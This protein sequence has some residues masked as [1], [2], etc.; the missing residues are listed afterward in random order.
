MVNKVLNFGVKQDNPASSL[1][2]AGYYSRLSNIK[3]KTA[4]RTE[5]NLVRIRYKIADYHRDHLLSIKA[6]YQQ[7]DRIVKS[8]LPAKRRQLQMLREMRSQYERLLA[9]VRSVN[10]RMKDARA[11]KK[12]A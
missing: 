11:F 1:A 7:H 3:L 10:V 2:Q 9:K 8:E 6:L 5:M 12:A 4:V